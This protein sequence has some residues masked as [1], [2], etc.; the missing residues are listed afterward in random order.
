MADKIAVTP[1]DFFL[2]VGATIALYVSTVSLLALWFAY[3]DRLL[4]AV[5]RYADP[6]S[7][8]IR[9]AVA[10]LVVIFPLFILLTRMVHTDIRKHAA[11]SELWIRK[12]LLMLTIFGAGITM[13]IDLIVLLNTFLGGEELTPAFLTKVFAVLLVIGGAFLYY[14]YEVRGEWEKNEMVSKII[15][16]IV[17]VIVL[18]SVVSAFFVIGTPRELRLLR[19]DQEKVNA[20]E[21]MQWQIINH[22]QQKARL[23]ENLDALQDPISGFSVPVDPQT[24]EGMAGYAYRI[25]APLSFELCATFNHASLGTTGGISEPYAVRPQKY[26]GAEKAFW[27]H[28]AGEVCFARAID[29]EAY[30]PL[31]KAPTPT[32]VLP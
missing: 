21:N 11:K 32:R 24:T 14:L 6:F 13:V 22:W 27:E 29:P 7:T 3:I 2:W 26:S 10:S 20:L 12:W 9:I 4:G 31:Q 1:K 30:P 19:Y 5:P 17:S 18:T 15:A 8:G 16:G 28:S 25:L 23:P